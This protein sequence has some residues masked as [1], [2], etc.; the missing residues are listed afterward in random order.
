MQTQIELHA[1]IERLKSIIKISEQ[2]YTEL[3]AHM[4][5]EIDAAFE[6]G[7]FAQINT[8]TK[9]RD[10]LRARVEELELKNGNW[11][12][13]NQELI[14]YANEKDRDCAY[15]KSR[16]SELFQERD[17]LR[18]QLAHMTTNRDYLSNEVREWK[19]DY[20][21]LEVQLAEAKAAFSDLMEERNDLLKRRDELRKQLVHL[22]DSCSDYVNQIAEKGVRIQELEAVKEQLGGSCNSLMKEMN[23]LREKLACR[24][25]DVESL[26]KHIRDL[27]GGT[28]LQ[29]PAL[30]DL[31]NKNI[32]L[33][34][35]LKQTKAQLAALQ[36]P[37]PHVVKQTWQ[38]VYSK[39]QASGATT[40]GELKAKTPTNQRRDD[41]IGYVFRQYMS[42]G[43]VKVELETI[44]ESK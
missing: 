32:S 42:D 27:E 36:P 15:H 43:S 40:S 38:A 39:P 29:H 37:A 24:D 2:A 18:T 31:V 16:V 6:E 4:Q 7:R 13:R 19:A 25:K 12:Q 1:E 34:A 14:N 9:E 17:E 22:S 21:K 23:Q 10:T 35:A 28:T 5:G 26:T 11:M 20:Q 30:I 44:G 41:T 3:G 8:D 33:N